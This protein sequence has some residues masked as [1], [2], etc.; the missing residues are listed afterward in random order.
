MDSRGVSG[1]SRLGAVLMDNPAATGGAMVMLLTGSLIVANAL[2]F[3]SGP[4]PAPLFATRP[5]LAPVENASELAVTAERIM[6]SV[7]VQDVQKELRRL[8]VYVGPLDGV[9]G[10]ATERAVRGYQRSQSMRETGL[11]DD[12]LLARLIL[13]AP[14]ESAS[15]HAPLTG[16]STENV[17]AM[18]PVP[19]QAPRTNASPQ[20]LSSQD[21]TPE[22][23]RV[24]QVQNLLSEL[25]Y[26]PLGVDGLLGGQTSGAIR[27]FELD[28]G[29]SV[30]GDVSERLMAELE[31]VSGK[32]ISR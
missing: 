3:Q 32:S 9:N 28:R 20:T 1:S 6:A 23:N 26:G 27:R 25:G 19:P 8:G 10:P 16:P 24:R 18:V 31:K 21:V 4:H 17:T 29:L 14:I 30:T 22:M 12:T 5:K 7:L 2:S 11:I 13:D 15:Q